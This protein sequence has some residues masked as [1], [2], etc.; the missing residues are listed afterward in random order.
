MQSASQQSS[1]LKKTQQPAVGKQKEVKKSQCHLPKNARGKQKH[2]FSFLQRYLWKSDSFLG[3]G[4]GGDE[5]LFSIIAVASWS[6][7]AVRR[8]QVRT[9]ATRNIQKIEL[10]S[11]ELGALSRH[12]GGAESADVI[13]QPMRRE[14]SR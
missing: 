6:A 1:R 7:M 4:T 11:S 8:R 13:N 12:P 3:G 2:T 14:A 9:Q 10:I 5:M